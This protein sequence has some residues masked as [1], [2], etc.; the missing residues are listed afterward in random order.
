MRA[1]SSRLSSCTSLFRFSN[2]ARDGA[3]EPF[4]A[5]QRAEASHFKMF[6]DIR[7]VTCCPRSSEARAAASKSIAV[8]RPHE[9]RSPVSI[10]RARTRPSWYPR[11]AARR[12]LAIS[13][14]LSDASPIHRFFFGDSLRGEV[15][16]RSPGQRSP[17]TGIASWPSAAGHEY[18]RLTSAA[19][20]AAAGAIRKADHWATARR[21]PAQI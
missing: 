6:G 14:G 9:R 4:T 20:T 2:C 13:R 7:K 3:K 16:H 10:A 19:I 15:V 11:W 12:R 17:A 21:E 5:A 18:Q 1:A 8:S